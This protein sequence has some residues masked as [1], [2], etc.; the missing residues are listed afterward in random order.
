MGGIASI[1]TAVITF[2]GG[3]PIAFALMVVAAVYILVVGEVPPDIIVQRII[4]S[5]RDSSFL[6]FPFFFFA[7]ELM[8]NG[9]VTKKLVRFAKATVGSLPGGL[10]VVVAAASMMFASLTGAALATVAAMGTLMYP[11]MVEAGYKR[12]FA[13]AVIAAASVMGPIIPP[14]GS[15]MLWG[16]TAGV[17]V[18][19]LLMAGWIPGIMMGGAMIIY[20]MAVAKKKECPV[21]EPFNLREFLSSFISAIPALLLPVIV[22]GLIYTGV[23][24]VS[25]SAVIA[26]FY[27]LLVNLVVY[28]DLDYR[29]I[30]SLAMK[31]GL[32]SSGISLIVGGGAALSWVLTRENVPQTLVNWFSSLSSDG[33]VTG[34]VIMVFLLILGCIMDNVPAIIMLA[35]MLDTLGRSF[36]FHSI[37]WGFFCT[38][39]LLLGLLTPPV[40]M[41]LF[42][43]T[44]LTK[45]KFIDLAKEVL[46]FVFIFILLG[47]LFL[48]IPDLTMFVPNLILSR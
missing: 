24:T 6:A 19:Q 44:D 16:I 40:G 21:G 34:F 45:V 31:A 33:L 39:V 30:P 15:L 38:Y 18:G 27:A 42:V 43:T 25:E 41:V 10:A 37:H 29:L 12:T 47:V 11:A 8:N 35:P 14:S 36:G 5:I 26:V 17:S 32:F 48:I 1:I 13:A 4:A 9:G 46:P 23:C 22:L 2:L 20:I 7:A 3:M 28:R